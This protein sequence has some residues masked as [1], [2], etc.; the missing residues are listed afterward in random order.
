MKEV[1]LGAMTEYSS[2]IGL[3]PQQTTNGLL[4]G[5]QDLRDM[6]VAD[7]G[8]RLVWRNGYSSMIT[9]SKIW[10]DAF[11]SNTLHQSMIE[12]MSEEALQVHRNN[13]TVLTRSSD[14][15]TSEYLRALDFLGLNNGLVKYHFYKDH[16]EIVYYVGARNDT[17]VRDVFLNK[18]SL[19][20]KAEQKMFAAFVEIKASKRFHEQQEIIMNPQIIDSLIGKK[21]PLFNDYKV[22]IDDERCQL[23]TFSY[24][25]LSYFV[26]LRFECSNKYLARHFEVSESTIK[27]DIAGLKSKLNIKTREGL[28]DFAN[29]PRIIQLTKG[30]NII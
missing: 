10:V 13:L 22:W 14:K 30:M 23:E 2:T 12:H 27:Q 18:I 24:K 29:R 6:G 16:I 4:E 28:V 25:E 20:E 3:L 15:L 8:Y 17:F 1:L 5:L 11:N 19:L 21:F 9:T 7:Y 26:L